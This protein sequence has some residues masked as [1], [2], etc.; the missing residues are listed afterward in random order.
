MSESDFDFVQ[1]ARTYV[2]VGVSVRVSV[3]VRVMCVWIGR[4]EAAPLPIRKSL[5]GSNHG[6]GYQSG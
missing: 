3:C 5:G 1:V 6:L 4:V 2:C